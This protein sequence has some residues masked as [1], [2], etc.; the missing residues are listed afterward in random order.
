MYC[1]CFPSAILNHVP[2][3]GRKLEGPSALK[4]SVDESAGEF[5]DKPGVMEVLVCAIT[6]LAYLGTLSFGFVY[7]DKPVIV[8][9]VVIHSWRFLAHY[10][11]P[12]ISAGIAPPSSGTFYRPIVL[13]WLRVNYAIFGLHPAGWHFAMLALHVLAT[14]LVFV[15]VGKLT[16]SRRTA[17]LAAVLFGLHPVH[18]ENVAWLS[19]VNDLLMTVFL[20]ASFLAYLDF[21]NGSKKIWMATS[22]LWFGLALLSKETAAVFPLLIFAFAA[23]FSQ[24]RAPENSNP[25]LAPLKDWPVL[26]LSAL[27]DGLVSV[28]Y[29]A[30]LAA[31]M[32]ARRMMLH[33]LAQPLAPLGWATMVLTWPSIL[34]FDLKHLLLPISSSEFYSLAYVTAPG[35]EN[36][37]LPIIFLLVALAVV[38]CLISKLPD[39]R[40]G[41]FALGWAIATILPTLYLRAIAPD[42]F[43]H[44]R[45]LYLPSVGIV[46]LVAL[47]LEQISASKALQRAVVAILCTAAFVG[48][49]MHQ[50]QWASNTLLYQNAMMYA[51]QNP[52]V[53]V[54]LANELANLGRYDR[55]IPLYLSA[56]QRDP[57]LWLSNYNLG[58]VYY[59]LGRFSE[60]EGYLKRA[61]QI[62][63]QDP[64]Q[65]IYLARAQMEQGELTEAAENAERALQRAPLS[66][67][68]HFV[69]AK[70]FEASGNRAGA[71]AEYQAEVA[72]HPENALARSEL[73]RLQSSQ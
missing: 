2:L 33:G 24:P 28:P 36:F 37:L 71:I 6:V 48:T 16:G 45:F 5:F 62:D 57:R 18:V 42:N 64:D 8:D 47:A 17:A 60:A 26:K 39:P 61:I 66:P 12:Q 50:V 46:I 73:Q 40:V 3:A 53:Q 65:F 69:L 11:I 59:R 63:D 43:V 58:Y 4:Q 51:P 13:L 34:W 29:F 44:D 10:F 30:V 38:A 9:N 19:S 56:L 72:S 27:Q 31:Y 70:I 41:V 7:D 32:A 25:V 14:Y 68:F 54:N 23:L 35:F 20:L 1:E 55:A 22:V 67:G 21:R 52:I 15:A 49:L